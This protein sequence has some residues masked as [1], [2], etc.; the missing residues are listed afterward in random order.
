M[1]GLVATGEAKDQLISFRREVHTTPR[2]CIDPQLTHAISNRAD[3]AWIAFCKPPDAHVYARSTHEIAQA[4]QPVVKQVGSQKL[5]HAGKAI[6]KLHHVKWLDLG[7]VLPDQQGRSDRQFTGD[8]ASR[9]AQPALRGWG[10]NLPFAIQACRD[11]KILRQVKVYRLSWRQW[12]CS[13]KGVGTQATT[14]SAC[15]IELVQISL[16]LPAM[17][18]LRGVMR[19][20]IGA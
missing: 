16:A 5:R 3:I 17:S 6:Y 14:Y 15:Q 2:T 19:Q 4:K 12:A 7:E 9:S 8:P 13:I 20:S 18:F 11:P 10:P 1:C